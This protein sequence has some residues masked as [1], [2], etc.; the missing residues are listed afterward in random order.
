MKVH[1][2]VMG[3]F[4]LLASGQTLAQLSCGRGKV[5]DLACNDQEVKAMIRQNDVEANRLRCVGAA[6]Y[7][8]K[9]VKVA[10]G[11]QQ[12]GCVSSADVRACVVDKLQSEIDYFHGMARCEVASH[13]VKFEVPDPS[14]VLA[15]PEVFNGSEVLVMGGLTLVDCAPGATSVVGEVHEY[16]KESV[17]LEIRFKSMPDK[18]RDFLCAKR[19]LAAWRG[20]LMLTDAQEPYLYSVDVLGVPLP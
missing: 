19:P 5:G 12:Y 10:W 15:H 9:T 4:A 11:R 16:E 3:L 18:Q 17:A 2:L 6:R 13:P 20:R 8:L 7:E 1:V 14:Y